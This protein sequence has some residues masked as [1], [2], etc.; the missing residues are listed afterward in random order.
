MQPREPDKHAGR[1]LVIGRWIDVAQAATNPTAAAARP[2]EISAQALP[3]TPSA[4]ISIR[5]VS[6]RIVQRLNL[7]NR[8]AINGGQ[9]LRVAQRVDEPPQDE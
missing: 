5:T 3:N 1:G 4:C 9:V 8:P 2:A 7:C 6:T